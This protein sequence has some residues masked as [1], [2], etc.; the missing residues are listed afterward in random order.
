MSHLS[1]RQSLK[2]L[3]GLGCPAVN[4]MRVASASPG[5]TLWQQEGHC[6]PGKSLVEDRHMWSQK[7]DVGHPSLHELFPI[8]CDQTGSVVPTAVMGL[9]LGKDLHWTL[10]QVFWAH[11]WWCA[12][13]LGPNVGVPSSL[14]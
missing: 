7:K 11:S 6:V 5:L 1:E 14:H 3:M 8:P 2:P 4:R 12:V 9:L 10:E 13:F